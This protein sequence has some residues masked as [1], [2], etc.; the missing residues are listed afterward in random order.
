LFLL[1]LILG[2]VVLDAAEAAGKSK[3]DQRKDAMEDAKPKK[4]E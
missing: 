3:Q 2:A 4:R 1:V